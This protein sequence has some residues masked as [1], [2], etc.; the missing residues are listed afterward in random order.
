MSPLFMPRAASRITLQVTSVRV[1]RVQAVTEDDARAEGV[2][3]M[4]G[5]VDDAAICRAAK[6]AGVMM[7]SR[8]AQFG[9]LWD[10]I[11]GKRAPWSAN[12]WVWVVG[13][14]VADA[15]RK[16]AWHSP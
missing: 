1:E 15:A 11:N 9:A 2:D 10:S 12:P 14:E 8:S 7:E 5:M 4:D 3:E 16:A 6:T 13:F